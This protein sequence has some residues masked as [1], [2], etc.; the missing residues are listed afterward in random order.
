MNTRMKALGRITL[1]Q[2]SRALAVTLS[3]ATLACS[4]QKPGAAPSVREATD[5]SASAITTT[6]AAGSDSAVV[7]LAAATDT[8]L[9]GTPV[10]LSVGHVQSVMSDRGFWIGAWGQQVYVVQTPATPTPVHG[11]EAY[12]IIGTVRVA[13]HSAQTAGR[14]MAPID[15]EALHAQHI[16]IAADSIAPSER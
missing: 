1:A 7:H 6:T 15:L 14:G 3:L 5:R 4:D 11:G 16:Y 8:T 13:P 9:A 12:S 10:R 2:S